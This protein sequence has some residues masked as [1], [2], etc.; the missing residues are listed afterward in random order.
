MKTASFSNVKD[1]IGY[2]GI[3]CGSCLV[4]NGALK[5]LTKW[6]EKTTE[7]YGLREWAFE[8]RNFEEF[9]KSLQ[10]ICSVSS[11]SGCLKGGGKSNCEIRNCALD[12]NTIFCTDCREY[13]KCANSNSIRKMREGARRADLLVKEKNVNQQEFLKIGMNKLKKKFPSCIQ[14]CET[15]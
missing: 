11:C 1:Q 10:S 6:Y 15:I 9:K 13:E 3:W 12:R 14:L 8:N 2:C 5:E 7:K 4:G